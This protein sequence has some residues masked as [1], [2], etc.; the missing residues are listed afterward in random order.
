MKYLLDSDVVI[1]HLRGKRMIAE[2]IAALGMSI[3]VIT[4][5]ELYYGAFKSGLGVDVVEKVQ[6][7][8]RLL[9]AEMLALE[10]GILVDY[11]R[12]KV[13]LE[14]KGMRLDDFDLLI[15]ATAMYADLILVTRNL[16]HF[17]RI[18]GLRLWPLLN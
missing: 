3:S 2:E 17:Q 7:D 12:L 11:A 14:T 6:M 5:A 1:D 8:L 18:K 16:K 10:E 13:D 4:Q 15:A 9:G